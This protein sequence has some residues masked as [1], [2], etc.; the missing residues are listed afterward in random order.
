M[1]SSIQEIIVTDHSGHHNLLSYFT[2]LCRNCRNTKKMFL[3]TSS[4]DLNTVLREVL[5]FMTQLKEI[6]L[7][8]ELTEEIMQI[9]REN[10]LNIEIIESTHQ[11]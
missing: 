6:K 3:N 11:T 4:G 2:G 10:C 1:L 9:I 8:V 7:A 5:P